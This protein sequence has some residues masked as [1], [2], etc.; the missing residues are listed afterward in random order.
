MG[1][2][3]SK[4]ETL[5]LR[6]GWHLFKHLSSLLAHSRMRDLRLLLVISSVMSSVMLS[7][8]LSDIPSFIMIMD[9]EI[10]VRDMCKEGIG[11]LQMAG[12]G[13]MFEMICRPNMK[14]SKRK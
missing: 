8:T 13:D 12:Q 6:R 4:Y 3:V 2:S 10:Y 11:A 7:T 9:E 1:S 5:H 14:K